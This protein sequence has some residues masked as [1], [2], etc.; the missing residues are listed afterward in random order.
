MF[1]RLKGL[2]KRLKQDSKLFCDYDSIIQEQ[3]RSG[4]VEI[5]EEP[6]KLEGE[7]LHYLPHH[8]VLRCDKSTTKT[9]VV[10]DASAKSEG[11]SLNECLHI[12]PKFNQKILEILIRFRVHR[13]ALVADIEKAFLMISVTPSDRDV[14]RF[15]WLKDIESEPPDI[16]VLRFKR[17]LFGVASSPFLLNATVR[18]HLESHQLIYPSTVAKVLRS[19][20][21][22]DLVCSCVDEREA[23]QLFTESRSILSKGGFNLRKFITNEFTL[24]QEIMEQGT[25]SH[26]SQHKVLGVQWNI[27]RDEL[28]V[29]VS[30]VAEQAST[31]SPTKRSVVGV[32]SKFFDPLGILSPVIIVFK[33]FLQELTKSQIDWDQPIEGFLLDKWN[34]LVKSLKCG[35]IVTI[36]RFVLNGL[37]IPDSYSLCGFSDASNSAYAAVVYLMVTIGGACYTRLITSK[38]RV[39]P[40]KTQTIPRLELI[41]AL[42]LARLVSTVECCLKEEIPLEKPL[43]FTDSKV[44]L[45]WIYGLDKDWKPFVQNRAEEIRKFVPTSQWR[46]CPGKCNPADYPS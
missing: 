20:Y 21:V 42:L 36:P 44:A 13:I 22:D 17:V 41:G 14:L 15:L 16:Q 19:M 39:A 26:E 45:Y 10:Y 6:D 5:V 28:V 25:L 1:R 34:T 11:S 27:V 8:A 30:E 18:H 37:G 32:V 23:H 43:C 40:V 12:G 31:C 38:T 46:H 4:V 3:L 7:R 9:R 35:P 2:L 24:Q 33:L 29:D